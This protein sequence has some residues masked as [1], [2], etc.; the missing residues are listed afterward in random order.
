MP[1]QETKSRHGPPKKPN[2]VVLT[3][4]PGVGKTTLLNHLRFMGYSTMREVSRDV[5]EEQI[6][7]DSQCLPWRDRTAFQRR[8]LEVQLEREAQ[9]DGK[10][11]FLDRGIPDG[12]AYL[13]LDNLNVFTELF[14]H[15][16]RRYAA[17]F[18]LKPIFLYRNDIVR[19]E[20]QRTAI[21]LHRLVQEVYTE[22]KYD[23]VEIPALPALGRANFVVQTLRALSLT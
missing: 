12:I 20:D 19:A 16:C 13:R 4:G 9:V 7:L 5:I 22:L 15:S 11:G 21:Q 10:V 3:G 1:G 2:L 8:V 18:L 14:E 6:Q 23:V 17:V